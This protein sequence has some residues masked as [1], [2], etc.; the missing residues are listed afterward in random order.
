MGRG[1]GGGGVNNN[2]N[3]QQPQVRVNSTKL[4]NDQICQNFGSIFPDLSKETILQAY[5][6]TGGNHD[7]TLQILLKISQTK[8]N[9]ENN[10]KAE[11][12]EASDKSSTRNDQKP[13]ERIWKNP[14]EKNMSL[15]ERRVALYSYAKARYIHKYGSLE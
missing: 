1:G 15:E 13:K 11:K 2:N 12:E 7:S 8:T 9:N 3:N 14:I 4:T 5:N 10:S 6:Q